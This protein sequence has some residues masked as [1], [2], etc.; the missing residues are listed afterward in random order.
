LG[1]PVEEKAGDAHHL[2]GFGTWSTSLGKM[3]E[4]TWCKEKNLEF[5]FYIDDTW[6]LQP[7]I[8]KLGHK[9]EFTGL[10]TQER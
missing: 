5:F 9:Q 3:D 10:L 2:F 7:E 1:I 6:T 8:A 4:S